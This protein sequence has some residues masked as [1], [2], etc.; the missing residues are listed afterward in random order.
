MEPELR[1][2]REAVVRQRMTG[3]CFEEVRVAEDF[4]DRY[5][6][7]VGVQGTSMSYWPYLSHRLQLVQ[8]SKFDVV[9]CPMCPQMSWLSSA[10]LLVN[11]LDS[12]L[13]NPVVACGGDRRVELDD[14]LAQIGRARTTAIYR[15][16]SHRIA[17]REFTHQRAER[18]VTRRFGRRSAL[19]PGGSLPIGSSRGRRR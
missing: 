1:A 17:H 15:P 8:S 10:N 5:T 2:V 3:G 4:I 13:T 11:L 18:V 19:A 14:V 9:E 12:A 16:Q 7:V 6:L